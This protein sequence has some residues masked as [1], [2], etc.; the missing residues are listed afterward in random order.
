MAPSTPRFG[1]IA[2]VSVGQCFENRKALRDAGVHI[3][4]RAGIWG[5]ETDG[6]CSIVASGGYADD[7]DKGNTIIYTG[8]GQGPV[9]AS[10]KKSDQVWKGRNLALKRSMELRLRVRV[11]RGS[12][13]GSK[14]APKHGYRYDGL[15]R[16]TKAWTAMGKEGLKVCQVQLVRL[17]NQPPIPTRHPTGTTIAQISQRVVAR[18]RRSSPSSSPPPEEPLRLRGRQESMRERMMSND[19]LAPTHVS[20]M[21]PVAGP[22]KRLVEAV[23]PTSTTTTIPSDVLRPG[24]SRLA[25]SPRLNTIS[26]AASFSERDDD[27]MTS[28]KRA[29]SQTSSVESVADNPAP[30]RAKLVPS[31]PQSFFVDENNDENVVA[32]QLHPQRRYSFV[33]A[34]VQEESEDSRR[35]KRFQQIAGR[36]RY[37]GIHFRKHASG[38]L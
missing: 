15:Y 22:S 20:P 24:S 32:P 29:L 11:V 14:F 3:P 36:K 17:P 33:G 38:S 27:P 5:T 12:D 34:A 19:F 35:A 16:I 2:N 31:P 30:K 8:E 18:S 9:G 10:T 6:A 13:C 23:S 7:V 4:L 1:K 37:S 26:G 21:P 28:L 25:P